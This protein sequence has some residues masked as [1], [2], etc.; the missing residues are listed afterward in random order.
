MRTETVDVEG[1]G[2][3]TIRAL[4]P[5]R[6]TRVLQI[7]KLNNRLGEILTFGLV[8]P[9]FTVDLARELADQ[10]DVLDAISSAIVTLSV[11]R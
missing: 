8:S 2:P 11:L 1:F 3:V 9:A 6:L 10:P 4:E 7:S 5:D